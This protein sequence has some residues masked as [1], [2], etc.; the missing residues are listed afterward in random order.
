MMPA[1]VSAYYA[2]KHS[3]D[4]VN[5][6]DY[7]L[8]NSHDTD[9]NKGLQKDFLTSIASVNSLNNEDFELL[10]EMVEEL[11]SKIEIDGLMCQLGSWRCKP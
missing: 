7:S 5:N 6:Q 4:A 2:G 8:L 10:I 1:I 11:Q 3:V 9:I